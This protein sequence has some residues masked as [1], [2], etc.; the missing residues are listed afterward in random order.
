VA[1]C[2]MLFYTSIK[3]TTPAAR[4][5]RSAKQGGY[6]RVPTSRADLED[7]SDIQS[8]GSNSKHKHDSVPV[9]HMKDE[10]GGSA[11]GS[12]KM[13]TSSSG[14]ELVRRESKEYFNSTGIASG[15]S[16]V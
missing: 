5:A 16:H 6:Q 8:P 4:E 12:N 1:T 7:G 14:V 13:L 3:H 2:G 15:A 10:R 11:A 9:F